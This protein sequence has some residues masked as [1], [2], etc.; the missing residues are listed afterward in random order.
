MDREDIYEV[1]LAEL[2]DQYNRESEEKERAEGT[3]FRFE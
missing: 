2:S 1:K 3:G